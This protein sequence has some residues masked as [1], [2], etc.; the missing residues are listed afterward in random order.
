[1]NNARYRNAC[2]L[3]GPR[4]SATQGLRPW[5]HHGD[6]LL[7]AAAAEAMQRELLAE[8]AR[9]AIVAEID[10]L[11]RT[12][13]LPDGPELDK[14]SRY[15]TGLERNLLRTLHELQRLKAA[16]QGGISAPLALDVDLAAS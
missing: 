3:E 6:D 13:I 5:P 9:D 16:R 10:A 7:S 11:R 1:M 12:R 4:D 14:L 2:A 15:E 8:E